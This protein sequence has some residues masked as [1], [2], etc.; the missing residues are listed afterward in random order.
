[1]QQKGI[2]SHTCIKMKRT[3]TKDHILYNFV[4]I[5]HKSKEY[6]SMLL[7]TK[8]VIMFGQI[9]SDWKWHA[10]WGK[11]GSGV[12]ACSVSLS[13]PG[14]TGVCN[15]WKLCQLEIVWYV[16]FCIICYTIIKGF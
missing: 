7:E 5:K 6:E 16:H 12:T 9:R 10:E 14:Y 2:I 4:Y 15:L 13:G 8:V 11:V 1:M 3:G